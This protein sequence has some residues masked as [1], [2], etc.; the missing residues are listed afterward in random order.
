MLRRIIYLSYYLKQLEWDKYYLFLN[1]A[2]NKS[3]KSKFKIVLDSVYCVF[4]YN[5]GLIDYFIFRFYD[6]DKTERKKWVGTGYKYEYD[7]KMNP[8]NS[9]HILENKLEFY[10]VYSPFVIHH[11]CSI[12]D[13]RLDNERA[14]A[15]L[16]NPT[17]KI[18]VKDAF[19]QCGWQVE[20]IKVEDYSREKLIEYMNSKGFNLAEE[21]IV[22]HPRLSE[23]SD[24]GVNTVRIITQINKYG[25]VDI[26]GA[27]LR[28]SINN[29]VDN[30]AS[31]NIAAPID[32]E[33]GEVTGL[34]VYSDI[35]KEP[36]EFHPVTN[37]KIS[38]FQIPYW[39]EVIKL[40]KEAALYRTENK[41]VGWDIA[42]TENGPGL[43]E[44]NHNW[45][46]ILWQVPVNQGMKHIL[47][48][49]LRELKLET[50]S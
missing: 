34:G 11:T 13:L 31:G 6:K 7:L 8:R 45:C 30:M 20:V 27:R 4:R 33:T 35:T 32:I 24:T 41:S 22:Q 44:G 28:I 16:K 18:V 2:S 21:Y 9:R 46:K 37:V 36:V 15:V 19:G 50:V 26:L 17:G 43:I 25:G 47:E 14:K 42:I 12:D 48:K 40:A 3:Q 39:E 23:L 5:I 38:G 1:Y 49:Y 10:K 29:I